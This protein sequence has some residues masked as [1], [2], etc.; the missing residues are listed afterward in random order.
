MKNTFGTRVILCGVLLATGCAT[1]KFVRQATDPIAAKVDEV[2]EKTAKEGTSLEEARK[3]L[4]R[5]ETGINN[6]KEKADAADARATEGLTRA[7]EAGKAATEASSVSEKNSQDLNTLRKTFGATIKDL[8]DYKLQA[9]LMVNFGFGK[10]KLTPEAMEK[11]DQFVKE[12]NN[13]RR[14]FIAVEGFTD[15]TGSGEYNE[16][17]SRRRADRV[18]AYLVTK[19]DIPVYR[20]QMIGLGKEKPLDAGRNREARSRNRRVEVKLY[21]ADGNPTLSQL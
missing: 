6:A 21:T 18:V 15:R 1:K 10:D 2:S 17:L 19:H 12:H 9:E 3:D 16:V 11:L 20:I 5:H 14:Y 7:S 4:E 8:D 13:A